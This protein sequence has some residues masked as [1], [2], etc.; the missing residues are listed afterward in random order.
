[1]KK[2]NRPPEG[3]PWIWLTL[4]MM[5]SDAWRSAG[6]NCR[7][8]LDFL[9]IEFMQ[10]AGEGNGE[11]KAP[12]DQLEQIGISSSLISETIRE[13]EMLGLV[14]CHRGGMRVAT[15]YTLTWLDAGTE[16]ATNDWRAHRNSKLRPWPCTKRNEAQS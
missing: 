8:F 16:T 4:K 9:L 2:K 14:R 6:I 10:N 7:R 15:T 5:K 13:A 12:Y 3:Q 11:L 1:M